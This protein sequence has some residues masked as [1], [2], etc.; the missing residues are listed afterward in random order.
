M[1]AEGQPQACSTQAAPVSPVRSQHEGESGSAVTTGLSGSR[2]MLPE[3]TAVAQAPG[4][5]AVAGV[6][7]APAGIEPPAKCSSGQHA[8]LGSGTGSEACRLELQCVMEQMPPALA[9]WLQDDPA[10]QARLEAA[11]PKSLQEELLLLLGNVGKLLVEQEAASCQAAASRPLEEAEPAEAAAAAGAAAWLRLSDA[12]AGGLHQAG[13]Q[14]GHGVAIEPAAA[15]AECSADGSRGHATAELETA[16]ASPTEAALTPCSK[17]RSRLLPAGF[18]T[19]P[20]LSA[21]SLS[22]VPSPPSIIRTSTASKD[23][24]AA[25]GLSHCQ[26]AVPNSLASLLLA[27]GVMAMSDLDSLPAT[28]DVF[29]EFQPEKPSCEQRQPVLPGDKR[30]QGRL[31]QAEPGTHVQT[32]AALPQGAA[33]R[34]QEQPEPAAVPVLSPRPLNRLRKRASRGPSPGK[35]N[36]AGGRNTARRSSTCKEQGLDAAAVEQPQYQELR[37][38]APGP[39]SAAVLP[40]PEPSCRAP[41]AECPD[42]GQ[43]RQSR[44][45]VAG[46]FGAQA[47]AY[48]VHGMAPALPKPGQASPERQG[49]EEQ[50]GS[51]QPSGAGARDVPVAADA[52]AATPRTGGTPE[53]LQTD[54]P[55]STVPQRAHRTAAAPVQDNNSPKPPPITVDE[56]AEGV[57]LLL[58]LKAGLRQGSAQPSHGSAAARGG[59]SGGPAA[60]AADSGSPDAEAAPAA[61]AAGNSSS[62]AVFGASG[63]PTA[64]TD[65]DD[66]DD[67]KPAVQRQG[68][69]R[70]R[71]HSKQQQPAAAP[72]VNLMGH[73]LYTLGH[74]GSKLQRRVVT[75]FNSMPGKQVYEVRSGQ[76]RAGWIDLS[77]VEVAAPGCL[78]QQGQLQHQVLVPT[79]GLRLELLWPGENAWFAGSVTDFDPA[80]GKHQVQYEDGDVQWENLLTEEWRLQSPAPAQKAGGAGAQV[81]LPPKQLTAQAEPEP[82]AAAA[83]KP[84]EAG[85]SPVADSQL[86]QGGAARLLPKQ[87]N[88]QP[89]AGSEL[90]A[91]RLGGRSLGAEVSKAGLQSKPH[92]SPQS[93][94]VGSTRLRRPQPGSKRRPLE[95]G[96]DTGQHEQ[97]P[98]K[99]AR[100]SVRQGPTEQANAAKQRGEPAQVL[101]QTSRVQMHVNPVR[102]SLKGRTRLG[103]RPVVGGRQRQRPWAAQGSRGDQ[104]PAAAVTA[105]AAIDVQDPYLFRGTEQ[106]SSQRQAGS[107]APPR[108]QAGYSKPATGSS[109][110]AASAEPGAHKEG[111]GVSETQA[112]QHPLSASSQRLPDWAQV[113]SQGRAKRSLK[114]FQAGHLGS[115][116]VT[117]RWVEE[118]KH[119]GHW[120]RFEPF[121]VA[122]DTAAVGWP[123][124]MRLKA[125]TGRQ[126]GILSG[127]NFIIAPANPVLAAMV[128][129]AGGKVLGDRQAY[130]RPGSAAAARCLV[131]SARADGWRHRD[132]LHCQEVNTQGHVRNTQ[133]GKAVQ[134]PSSSRDHTV[135]HIVVGSRLDPPDLAERLYGAVSRQCVQQQ[136]IHVVSED[137]MVL[138]NSDCELQEFCA[139]KRRPP[140]ER[141]V[142]HVPSA[143]ELQGAATEANPDGG[144]QAAGPMRKFRRWLG[145]SNWMSEHDDI[146]TIEEIV[147]HGIYSDEVA[148]Q[149]GNELVL[150]AVTELYKLEAALTDDMDGH[151]SGSHY[152]HAQMYARAAA[153]V[154]ACHFRID[155]R[156]R[157]DQI[158]YCGAATVSK[159]H[160]IVNT[161]TC[162]QLEALRHD[163]AV[164]SSDGRVR[165]GTE[166]ASTRRAFMK[167]WGAGP[168]AAEAWYD[169]GYRTYEELAAD[170]VASPE[171]PTARGVNFT[172]EQRF[173]LE[174]REELLEPVSQEDLQEMQQ[175]LLA[176]FEAVTG[177]PPATLCEIGKVHEEEVT[178]NADWVLT[179][180]GGGRRGKPSHDADF[181]VT[182][183]HR[184]VEGILKPLVAHL[185][186][187]GQLARADEAFYR[188]NEEGVPGGFGKRHP[189]ASPSKAAVLGS[190]ADE[191][192]EGAQGHLFGVFKTKAGRWRRLDV[193]VAIKEEHAA[194]VLG[195]TGSRQWLRFLRNHAAKRGMALNSHRLVR[196]DGRSTVAVPEDGPPNDRSL[197]PQWP[198]G[199]LQQHE[200]GS[201]VTSEADILSLLG[202]PYRQPQERNA[203]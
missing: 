168:K 160:E 45:T 147:M 2:V 32:G 33:S 90:L 134:H 108:Q 27:G 195:W 50:Q 30:K 126:P 187:A 1:D 3:D 166:G 154:Q 172:K 96:S 115:W 128:E 56:A 70:G 156:L 189:A 14:R 9:A 36:A 40:V 130:P 66:E 15:A 117:L 197:S 85:G 182:H 18:S 193:I 155:G 39:G 57:Q 99:L 137:W 54:L 22:E 75:A 196:K 104:Q 89:E 144:A 173:W 140:E 64:E 192:T 125:S 80:E 169:A 21:A 199:W 120:L 71:S 150:A 76:G 191:R 201:C 101:A 67:F 188:M 48:V 24:K 43:P 148:V 141:F 46:S 174:H 106:Q 10:C 79:M 186:Q 170:A 59:G 129:C 37:A 72:Q 153:A 95:G 5:Q 29:P 93:Q 73:L 63:G 98:R 167:V 178:G 94:Q 53:G 38:A 49:G 152:N 162:Q 88:K 114:Y 61:E 4:T 25:G 105:A 202:V 119:A 60:V 23:S 149:H 92:T 52:A 203:P 121:E 161:G 16:A 65:S 78:H 35:E 185:Q 113:D 171:G 112:N 68:M 41:V 103:P 58:A 107:R 176:A 127:F 111:N 131:I 102:R 179:V 44:P 136:G 135:T 81:E 109:A 55:A 100:H 8:D 122:G 194:C 12:A 19:S 123:R 42:E 82:S 133:Y 51:W 146:T 157:P 47:P 183:H 145:A 132:A 7:P 31:Q 11:D 91:E 116:I 142:V 86:I 6:T 175:A 69:L 198:A 84:Q 34:A 26:T 139:K 180:V 151:G 62:H 118:S 74:A 143:D 190:T 184:P 20:V 87:E 97:G 28:E 83:A 110:A 77:G 124:T 164:S 163:Q 159:I 138:L 17:K 158:P 177:E 13:P 165:G 200:Q 181:V